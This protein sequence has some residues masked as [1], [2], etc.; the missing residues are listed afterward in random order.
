LSHQTK[1]LFGG[2]GEVGE[3]APLPLKVEKRS[4]T[5]MHWLKSSLHIAL[6]VIV[7][8]FLA[9]KVPIIGSLTGKA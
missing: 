8:L 3:P 7:V 4:S 9:N 1:H 6:V 5:K 2:G